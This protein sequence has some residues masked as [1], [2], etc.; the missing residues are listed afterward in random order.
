M[1]TA[2]LDR[3]RL[4]IL[5][6]S[7]SRPFSAVRGSGRL[8]LLAETVAVLLWVW[9]WSWNGTEDE[10]KII[11]LESLRK[12]FLIF[13]VNVVSLLQFVHKLVNFFGGLFNS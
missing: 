9:I 4:G 8:R 3:V 6:I 5:L 1:Q 11:I 12:L 10:K 7:G 13:G 2:I